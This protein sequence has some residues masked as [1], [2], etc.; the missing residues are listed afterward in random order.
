MYPLY[1]FGVDASGKG[2]VFGPDVVYALNS[3]A[4]PESIGQATFMRHA[5]VMLGGF[6]GGYIM[7]RHFPDDVRTT[8]TTKSR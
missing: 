3:I 6:L 8:G 4:R 1:S 5:G 2:S 7:R